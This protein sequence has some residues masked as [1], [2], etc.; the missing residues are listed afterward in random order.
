MEDGGSPICSHCGG[1]SSGFIDTE[2]DI[3]CGMCGF[4]VRSDCQYGA[5]YNHI[6][7]VSVVDNRFQ[8]IFISMNGLLV[9][10]VAS[11]TFLMR[12]WHKSYWLPATLDSKEGKSRAKAMSNKFYDL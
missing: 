7:A 1:D 11:L 12:M 6:R 3:V 10:R 8:R 5:E 4:V 2:A 9:S